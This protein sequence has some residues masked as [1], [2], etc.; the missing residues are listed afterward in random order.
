M[1]NISYYGMRTIVLMKLKIFIK[2]FQYSIIS[3]I[4]SSIIF[5]IILATISEFYDLR[6]EDNSSYMVF[7][8]PGIIIMIVIQET[9]ANISETLIH[10]KQTGS[11]NDILMSPISRIEI[12]LSLMIA[13]LFIG[14]II[15]ITNLIVISLFFDIYLYNIYRAIF[16]ISIT[17][18]IFGSFGSIIGF[19]SY[20]WDTQQSFFNFLIV[21]ISL[22]SGTFFSVTVIE[23]EWKSFFMLNPF[24]YL[25]SYFR[26][27]FDINQSYDLKVDIM[28]VIIGFFIVYSMIYIFKKG[29]KVI[30]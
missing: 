20:T 17:S 11:F 6:N 10:M 9:Y 24:Y 1:G 16:Y 25:V 3:P 15:C 23:S 26:K 21:P 4:V 2:E 13:S 8:I 30:N 5:I 14:L 7:V 19:V 28:L 29:Y 22:L 12:A 18:I 27:G